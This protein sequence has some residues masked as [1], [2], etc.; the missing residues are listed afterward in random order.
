V[1]YDYETILF[2]LRHTQSHYF[3]NAKRRSGSSDVRLKTNNNKLLKLLKERKCLLETFSFRLLFPPSPPPPP[4][5][6]PRPPP[7]PFHF[8]SLLR[9]QRLLG[10]ALRGINKDKQWWCK[11]I[12][13]RHFHAPRPIRLSL[14]NAMQEAGER[15]F[16]REGTTTMEQR[17]RKRH[18][19][20]QPRHHQ[21]RK[22]GRR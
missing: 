15:A 1:I 21:N 7:P 10:S 14:F 4:L 13:A 17:K 12:F 3:S 6:P 20:R 5:P 18:H 2:K 8:P 16:E 19:R 22:K 9:R 11:I